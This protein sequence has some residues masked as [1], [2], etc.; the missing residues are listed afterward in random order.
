MEIAS[1]VRLCPPWG[2]EQGAVPKINT[3]LTGNEKNQ[4]SVR[5]YRL[6]YYQKY[7]NSN[8]ND[9]KTVKLSP[10]TVY[11]EYSIDFTGNEVIGSIVDNYI[12]NLCLLVMY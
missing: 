9:Y 5:N 12:C 10:V 2:H 1:I 8:E 4:C 7:C 3:L 6:Y 11:K